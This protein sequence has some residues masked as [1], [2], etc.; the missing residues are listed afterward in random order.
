MTYEEILEYINSLSGAPIN[1]REAMQSNPNEV[2]PTVKGTGGNIQWGN[3]PGLEQF[4]SYDM[5]NNQSNFNLNEA[6][7]EIERLGYQVMRA[8]DPGRET[9]AEWVVGPDGKPIAQSAALTGTNDDNFKL[10]ALA[11]MGITGANVLGA[12]FG[13]TGAAEAGGVNP[14]AWDA[15]M[16]AGADASYT[17]GA[18]PGAG[19]KTLGT[20]PE[21]S[22]PLEPL[23]M[24]QP[25]AF[26]PLNLAPLATV[27]ASLPGAAA[28]GL[29]NSAL[30]AAA[31]TGTDLLKAGA[32]VAGAAAGAQEQPGETNSKQFTL[33]PRVDAMTFGPDG[34]LTKAYERWKANPTGQNQTM[35]DAQSMMRGLLTSN[36][37]RA[38]LQQQFSTGQGLLTPQQ[39]PFMWTPR[40][41]GG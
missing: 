2:T 37:L 10:A 36:D 29:L 8:D 14:S 13:A 40:K 16:Q 12:G 5:G 3:V 6:L 19:I 9:I 17:G 23:A 35:T 28:S 33:D 25:L 32:V 18:V 34:L 20:L 38:G 11:A 4:Y 15:A 24:T 27:P 31:S 26:E 39:N 21:L 30:P 1:L 22:A 41:V 7:P